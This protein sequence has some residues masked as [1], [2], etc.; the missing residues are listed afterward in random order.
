MK[1]IYNSFLIAF[2]MYSRIPMPQCQWNDEN[3]AYAMCFF[4]WV[5]AVIGVA[6]WVFGVFGAGI[7][8]PQS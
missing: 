8:L 3:M 2:S 1:R 7:G 6:T 5:G 4:P